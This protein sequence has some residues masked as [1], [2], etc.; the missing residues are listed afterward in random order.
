[1]ASLRANFAGNYNYLFMKQFFFVLLLTTCAVS[2]ALAQ[3]YGH[4]NFGNLLS[5]MDDVK[6]AQAGL[7]AY[8][9]EQIAIGEKLVAEFKKAYDEAEAKVNNLTPKELKTIQAKLEKDQ[10]AIQGFEQQMGR[11]V[12]LKRQKLLGPIIKKAKEAVS[13]VAKA[14]GYQ[15][16][17]D[18][19]IF[20]TIMFAEDATDLLAMVKARLGIQ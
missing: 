1:M 3:K 5:Q 12:E 10:I 20:G 9:K 19:S 18:S 16:V 15:L 2:S 17:F 13:A 4:V 14:Q 7:Q 6:T 11:N 8:E